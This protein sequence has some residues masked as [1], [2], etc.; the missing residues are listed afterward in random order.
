MIKAQY[1]KRNHMLSIIDTNC[2]RTPTVSA[3]TGCVDLVFEDDETAI[4][5]RDAIAAEHPFEPKE[6]PAS[7]ER[8]DMA[9]MSGLISELEGEATEEYIDLIQHRSDMCDLQFC[10]GRMER[11]TRPSR[12]ARGGS[13]SRKGRPARR[14][15]HE[16]HVRPHRIRERR[17]QLAQ[18]WELDTPPDGPI[19][20]ATSL[21]TPPTIHSRRTPMSD[22]INPDHYRN[23]PFECIELTRL[24]SFEWGNVVKYC[25]RWKGKNGIEDLD[26]AV[27]YAKDAIMHGVPL[28]D[29]GHRDEVVALLS[30]LA[31]A[32]WAD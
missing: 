9:E 10:L 12:V 8:R 7:A 16:R 18:A 17:R 27:W 28:T 29:E 15:T 14:R 21:H 20:N 32:D 26:K 6:P 2:S 11:S 30:T 4:A 13:G 24:L 31:E 1:T 3:K 5:V 19:S 25:F 22:S 23:G